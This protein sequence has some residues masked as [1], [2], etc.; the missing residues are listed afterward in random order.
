MVKYLLE[1][2]ESEKNHRIR[3]AINTLTT[4]DKTRSDWN[5]DL[6]I[7]EPRVNPWE[8]SNHNLAICRNHKLTTNDIFKVPKRNHR[9]LWINHQL[10][11]RHL[12]SKTNIRHS[13]DIDFTIIRKFLCFTAKYGSSRAFKMLV[14][15]REI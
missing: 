3:K 15:A 8:P 6:D 7:L 2:P 12:Y 14:I 13:D 4:R 11:Y 1:T 9:V 5:D 10:A